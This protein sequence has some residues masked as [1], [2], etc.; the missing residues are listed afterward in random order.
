MRCTTGF[1]PTLRTRPFATQCNR[2]DCRVGSAVSLL[3]LA[4][5]WSAARL[6]TFAVSMMP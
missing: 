5:D 4:I 1:P 2:L 3:N 6:Q